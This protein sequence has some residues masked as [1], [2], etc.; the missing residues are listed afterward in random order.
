MLNLRLENFE[1]VNTF[2]VHWLDKK[3]YTYCL[4][5]EVRNAK[6]EKL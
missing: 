1:L 6:E 4:A 5:G 3:V 2:K